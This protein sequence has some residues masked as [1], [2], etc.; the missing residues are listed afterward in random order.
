LQLSREKEIKGAGEAGRVG[1]DAVSCW[2]S[3]SYSDSMVLKQ[4]NS[5]F[6]AHLYK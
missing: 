6:K 1:E 3:S 5:I 2:C 4:Y